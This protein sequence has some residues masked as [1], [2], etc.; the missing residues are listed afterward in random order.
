MTKSE[1]LTLRA[2]LLGGMDD[3]IHNVINNPQTT[4][5][6]S[7]EGIGVNDEL[8]ED[9]LLHIAEDDTEWNRLCYLFGNLVAGFGN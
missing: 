5:M 9:I 2:N 8:T 3:Y 1:F 4:S 6:W 7:I